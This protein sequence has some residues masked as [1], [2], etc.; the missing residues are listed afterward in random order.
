M[1][2]V[3][4][5]QLTCVALL[6]FWGWAATYSSDEVIQGDVYRIIYV[7]VPAAINAF[8][9]TVVLT[10]MS[11]KGLGKNGSRF[12]IGAQAA[13]EVG[14]LFTLLTLATGSIWGKPTW[15]TWW[16]WDARL[17][18]TLLLAVLYSAFLLLY[19]SI[20]DRH[21]RARVSAVLSV[22]ILADVPIIYKSVSWWRTLHQPPS[23]GPSGTSISPEILEPLIAAVCL[24]TAVCGSFIYLRWQNLIL[25]RAVK[26]VAIQ[27]L[28]RMT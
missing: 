1:R 12:V 20:N 26:R 7:H 2:A 15:G 24:T 13:A 28:Q 18:T 17:T 27:T 8:L 21:Q 6:A 14:L 16:T 22:L 11:L 9:A 10:I 23:I 3:T 4:V 19:H 25:E 5:T